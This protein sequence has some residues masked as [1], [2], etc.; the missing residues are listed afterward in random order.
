[1]TNANVLSSRYVGPEINEIFSEKGKAIAERE[2]WIA[3]M[4]AQRELG[5]DIPSE[6]IEKFERAK[7]DVNLEL[8]KEIELKTKHDVK[9]KIEAFVQTAKAGQHVHKGM[10]SR[11]L[12]ENVEQ[13]QIRNAAKI[14]F[15]RFISVLRHMIDNS[16]K[17]KDYVLTAR[18]HN[19]PA[20]PTLLGRRFSMWAEELLYHLKNFESFIENY[21][22][23]GIKGP[24]GT[25]FDMLVLFDGD[26]NKVEKLERSIAEKLG[27]KNVANSP[28]QVY[29]RSL[30][31]AMLSYLVQFSSA[32]ENFAKTIRIMAGFGLVNESFEEG[33][34]GSSAMPYK[35][36]TI[37]CERICGF[38]ELL[39][40]YADGA[41]RLVGDQWQEGDVSCSVIRRVVM[42]DAFYVADGLCETVLT[43][44][45]NMKAYDGE[46][47]QELKKFLPFMATTELL[48][49]IIKSGVGREDAHNIIKK[50][51]V[52]ES[53]RMKNEGS[54][55]NNLLDLLASDPFFIKARITKADMQAALEDTRHFV[56]NANEQIIL[57]S[58]A[59]K[60]LL[61]KYKEESKYEPRPIL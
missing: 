31:Y 33:Q 20:Q 46:I 32:C 58:E 43:I 53:Q 6:D 39:K 51:A 18:T 41:S 19:Q 14:I 27:F 35:M 2:L 25:Q 61:E 28:G 55:V 38:A 54:S 47:V 3:V 24:V 42:T 22:L 52:S 37:R 44:L 7:L 17:Y 49:K 34:V 10:T 26:K 1:M 11:D 57:V 4:M 23:R 40:M 21:P 36:N 48:Q 56:G 13:M 9:A 8:I 59:A 5:L 15:G 60:I 50:Y 12:T 29:P 30:D 45:N 16:M